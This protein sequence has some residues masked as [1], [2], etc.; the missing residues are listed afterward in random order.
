MELN[1]TQSLF[2]SDYFVTKSY[3]IKQGVVHK[4]AYLRWNM[5]I[6]SSYKSLRSSC[7]PCFITSGCFFTNNHPTCEKKNPLFALCGSA[8]VSEY[9]W[10]TRWSLAHSKM[11]FSAAMQF[12]IM[13]YNF[14]GQVALYARWV[15]NRW[16]PTVTP[17]PPKRTKSTLQ[18]QVHGLAEGM[19]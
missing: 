13:R 5:T 6:L 19:R 17:I 11:S 4:Q 3:A 2:Y 18:S 16:A 8:S 10:W 12:T 9:L 1:P 15:H 7:F 14:R